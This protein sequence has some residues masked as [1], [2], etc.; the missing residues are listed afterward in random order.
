MENMTAILIT[1]LVSSTVVLIVCT[2][3]WF[4]EGAYT[5]QAYEYLP[6]SKCTRGQTVRLVAAPTTNNKLEKFESVRVRGSSW[7]R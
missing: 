6:G 1:I 3:M 5:R 2:Y 4:V 7:V